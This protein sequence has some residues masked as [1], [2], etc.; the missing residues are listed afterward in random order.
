MTSAQSSFVWYE[1]MTSDV[2]AAKTFY[3]DVVGWQTEDMPMPGMTYT[4]LSMA[5]TQVGGMMTLPKDA[6][7]AGMR[8][9]WG[10]YI[11][12]DDVDAA[13]NKVQDLGG[14]IYAAP[15]DIPGNNDPRT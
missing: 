8:P 14:K 12:V 5:K 9:C 7:D 1:L 6:C 13:A 4:M 2:A 15:A 11:A 3:T 10:S